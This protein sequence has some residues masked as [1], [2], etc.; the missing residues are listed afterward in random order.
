MDPRTHR[1]TWEKVSERAT[2]IQQEPYH[3]EALALMTASDTAEKAVSLLASHR[4]A[5]VFVRLARLDDKHLDLLIKELDQWLQQQQRD[6]EAAGP[7]ASLRL[8]EGR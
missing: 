7:I 5:R 2:A 3:E 8:A 6:R 1:G 4:M